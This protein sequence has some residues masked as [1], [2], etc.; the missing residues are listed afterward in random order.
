[1]KSLEIQDTRVAWIGT[2]VMGSWMCR[3]VL[4][5]GYS[6]TVYN[7]TRE[8]AE[9]LV[10]E[11]ARSA[12]S[13]AEAAREADVVFSMVAF[14][15]DVEEVYFG[16][17]GILSATE[18]GMVLVDMTTTKPALARRIH[19]AAVEKGAAALDAPVSGGDVGARKA[20][21][22]VMVGGDTEV[23]H[24]AMPL[25][26]CM[27]R[28]VVHQG[29][30]GA[31][32][33]AKMCNQIVVAGTMTGVCESLVYGR[34]AGLDLEKVLSSIAGGAAGCWTLDNLAPRIL[35]QDF[36]PGFFVEHFIKD[37][38]IALEEA[39]NMNLR[40]PGLALV[41]DLYMELVEA[42]QGRKGTQALYLA[43]QRLDGRDAGQ[44]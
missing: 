9:H 21:L 29:G 36:D 12:G 39:E 43:L 42:G 40:L 15:R 1:M 10:R 8:R 6:V 30:P 24:A 23:V 14:P 20:D 3:H 16:P 41:R 13:P 17:E 4:S 34:R 31:G 18:A 38:E 35:K 2:G 28:D 5:A 7:R 26:S 19:E 27:A 32:Q 33:H 22:S 37:M 25:F 11:G 44:A